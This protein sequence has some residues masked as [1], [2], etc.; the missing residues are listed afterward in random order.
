MTHIAVKMAAATLSGASGVSNLQNTIFMS[1]F[2]QKDV[3]SS[4][5][6]APVGPYKFMV[7]DINDYT[8]KTRIPVIVHLRFLIRSS[9]N[10]VFNHKR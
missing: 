3:L 10:D 9:F 6:V 5:T 7:F 1:I 4:Y 2:M 8:T